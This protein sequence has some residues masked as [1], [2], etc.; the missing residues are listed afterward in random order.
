MESQLI[1]QPSIPVIAEIVVP[2]QTPYVMRMSQGFNEALFYGTGLPMDEALSKNI[3]RLMAIVAGTAQPAD[4]REALL[5]ELMA[6]AYRIEYLATA[7][8]GN[9]THISDATAFLA[10]FQSRALS[11]A[12]HAL[13][14]PD[15]A[16]WVKERLFAAQSA[17]QMTHQPVQPIP[18]ALTPPMYSKWTSMDR[19]HAQLTMPLL[20]PLPL[21]Q[22]PSPDSATAH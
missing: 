19:S 18:S 7:L 13:T 4:A 10:D 16:D 14:A 1:E 3:Q 22:N 11:L 17:W 20:P 8:V 12:N 6:F 2:G 15:R 9:H 21:L 5:S